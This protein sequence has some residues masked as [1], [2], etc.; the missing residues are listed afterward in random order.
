MEPIIS[1]LK[2]LLYVKWTDINFSFRR[3]PTNTPP[4]DS[5]IL[6]RRI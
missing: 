2:R 5:G 1:D 3:K 4:N 6:Q